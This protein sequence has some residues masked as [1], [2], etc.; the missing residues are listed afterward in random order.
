MPDLHLP[1]VHMP[2]FDW[3]KLPPMLRPGGLFGGS[4]PEEPLLYDPE[5]YPWAT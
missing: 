1:D 3:E 5:L 2:K 4:V